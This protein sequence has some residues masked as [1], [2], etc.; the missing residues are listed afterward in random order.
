MPEHVKNKL[1]RIE[2]LQSS[3]FYGRGTFLND[4]VSLFI[5]NPN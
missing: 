5:L 3:A 4:L 2:N 1:Y